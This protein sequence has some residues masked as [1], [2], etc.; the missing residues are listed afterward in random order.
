MVLQLLETQKSSNKAFKKTKANRE[1]LECFK[2][3]RIQFSISINENESERFSKNQTQDF[4]TK[5]S[6]DPIYSLNTSGRIFPM[7]SIAETLIGKKIEVE[8]PYHIRKRISLEHTKG[9]T[10]SRTIEYQNF[11][12]SKNLQS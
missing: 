4:I 3:N 12:N 6:Y 8:T 9:F 2:V 11:C 7:T 1:P 5:S 10:I